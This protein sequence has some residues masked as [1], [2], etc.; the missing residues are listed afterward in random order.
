MFCT[1][2][3]SCKMY[4]KWK[5]LVCFRY[6]NSLSWSSMRRDEGKIGVQ[7]GKWEGQLINL[8]AVSHTLRVNAE[9]N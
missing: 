9:G 7:I 3:M 6:K 8:H 1:K 5:S 4:R 2:G